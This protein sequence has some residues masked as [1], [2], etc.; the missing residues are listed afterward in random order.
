[1]THQRENVLIGRR[2][3]RKEVVGA[4][5]PLIV[6]SRNYRDTQFAEGPGGCFSPGRDERANGGS[7]VLLAHEPCTGLGESAR[8]GARV[9]VNDLNRSAENSPRAVHGVC[10]GIKAEAHLRRVTIKTP[11]QREQRPHSERRALPEGRDRKQAGGCTCGESGDDGSTIERACARSDLHAHSFRE[12]V[13]NPSPDVR[14]EGLIL[15]APMRAERR[16]GLRRARSGTAVA[17]GNAPVRVPPADRRESH[18]APLMWK[19]A[20]QPRR[21]FGTSVP[22]RRSTCPGVFRESARGTATTG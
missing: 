1:M 12:V 7:N 4:K 8:G 2:S 20:P 15:T 14:A 10:C 19:P 3:N 18:P 17:T 16:T 6:G 22:V 11:G 5:Q 13:A 21:L 9:G